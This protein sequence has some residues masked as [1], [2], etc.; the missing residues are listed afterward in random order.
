MAKS[1]KAKRQRRT[2]AQ[3]PQRPRQKVK[4]TTRDGGLPAPEAALLE[5]LPAAIAVFDADRR[6]AVF[7]TAFAELG[8]FPK[9][10][11]K[12]GRA[13]SEFQRRDASLR[14]RGP[15]PH[16]V[17]LPGGQV[18]Q[19]SKRSL[20]G[21][22]ILLC[23]ENVTAERLAAE[24]LDLVTRAS[25]E[26]TYDWD[27][28]NDTIYY[29][30]QVFEAIGLRRKDVPDA[31]AWYERIHPDDQPR[32]SERLR[33]HFRGET[34]RF[35]VEIRFRGP[36]GDW[37]WARQHGIGI[38]DARGKVVRMVGSTGDIDRLKRLEQ[39]LAESEARY[40]LATRAATEGIYDWNVGT[41]EL[42]LSDRAKTFFAIKGRKLTPAVWSSRIHAEDLPAY[43][44]V[45]ARY[46]KGEIQQFEHEYRIQ[47]ASGSYNWIQD[48][49]VAERGESGRVQ[50]LVG[51]ITDI[52]ARKQAEIE[53]LQAHDETAAALERQTATAEI[54]R[55]ISDS[56]TDVAP[57]LKAV[58][59]RAARICDAHT[60]D[61][62]LAE[63]QSMRMSAS[64]GNIGRPGAAESIPL[65]RE[66]VMGRAIVDRAVVQ[67]VDLQNPPEGEYALGRELARKYGHRTILAVPLLREGRALGAILVRRI[68]VR[69]FEDKHISLL[70]TFAD[71]AAIAIENVRLFNET[72]E[73][74]ERQTATA[75]VLKVISSS[76][77][78]TKPVFE[79][80]IDSCQGLIPTTDIVG[81]TFD[82]R[83]FVHVVATRGPMADAFANH[84]ARP[85]EET[86][87]TQALHERRVR[88]YP[89]PINGDDVPER[90]R[91]LSEQIGNFSWAV[92]PIL[93]ETRCVG[94]F[95]MTRKQGEVFADKEIDL[96]K[97]FADQ[98]AIAIQNSRLFNETEEAL[99]RQTATAE[100]LRVISSTPTDTQPVFD[101]IAASARR[102]CDA[103]A[104]VVLGYDGRVID[105]AALDSVNVEG[106]QQLRS[107]FPMPATGGSVS[108]RAILN[109]E[110]T[111]VPDVLEI[112]NYVLGTA[113][114]A[115]GYRS[116]LAVPMLREGQ[117]IGAITVTRAIPGLFPDRQ[118]EL[119][120]AFADQAVIAIENVRLFNETKEALE[121]QTATA[122]ILAAMSD[123]MTDA[124]PVFDAIV[125][126]LRRLFDTRF[127]VVQLLNGETIEM[128]AADGEPGFERLRDHYPRPLDQ[129]TIGAQTMLARRVIQCSPVIGNPE[130]AIGTQAFA[131]EFG[132]NA[133]LFAPMIRG[134]A[135]IGVIGI[136]HREPRVFDDDEV[137]LIKAFA[138]QAVIAIE[139]VRLFN[140]LK[141]RTEALTRSVGQLT[142]LGEVGQAISATLDVETVLKTIVS[143]AMRLTGLDAGVIYEYDIASE[144]F[145]LRASENFDDETVGTLRGAEL[146]VGEGAVGTS[147]SARKPTQVPDTHAPGYPARLR[148]ML[149]GPGFRAVLAVPLLREEQIIGALMMLRRAPGLFPT[150]VVELLSTF[151]SQSA[152]AMQ[153]ARLFREIGDKG[154]QLQVANQHKSEFLANMSH[155]LRTPLNAII[156]FS[157]ALDERYFGEL[158]D[159]QAE[160][161][162]DI[163]GSGK[164]L[165]SLINDILDLSKIEAG[166]MD[167]DLA[168]F[169]LPGA[170]DNALTL[171]RERAQ[172]HGVRLEHELD[173]AL[174][175]V[176]ADER[177]VKQIL[178]NLLS[179]AVKFTPEGGR[180]TVRGRPNGNMIEVAVVDTGVGIAP[181]DQA[182]VFEEFKQVGND[183]AAKAQGTGLGLALTKRF[184]ELHGGTIG[185]ES[186]P[187]KG[188][189]FIFTL[190][191]R[192]GE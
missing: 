7:N 124:Q 77:S 172:R 16:E 44:A 158:T 6:L 36:R 73:A 130:A 100:I 14:R 61:I 190:P 22:Q 12:P 188:S 84:A 28:V 42:Y 20:P 56:P 125:R 173:P 3:A 116:V 35:E 81:F 13:F 148:E 164:H 58:A 143:H 37:R 52:S 67:V 82:D 8:L 112:E 24:R 134:E 48:R 78:D 140:E 129:T 177:K 169:D 23:Y 156:G 86:F 91:K 146:R 101:A 171:V 1:S 69:P 34:D 68:E 99:E 165:L 154:Q 179:N 54:L 2:K 75:D 175:T 186:A 18:L 121:R 136:A 50:R 110:V 103:G 87:L 83:S 162:K 160:Y 138:D 63:G 47:S 145:Q 144:G 122:E 46:F 51:A 15:G 107:A 80:I 94:F 96:L 157:E 115:I 49:A 151:A 153:N 111:Q 43:R 41:G 64:V 187:G 59:E 183:V 102:L 167:L 192:G 161:V 133:A 159:K 149:D 55:V 135:V 90:L 119:L 142:A 4:P 104:V 26:G 108:T 141:S 19:A 66:T 5:A 32:Y 45:M 25:S 76:V 184:V 88:V 11:L 92:A 29:S 31:T 30:D 139:N 127:A 185:L 189:T 70:R 27:I 74:L 113:A 33:A 132:F 182:A 178:L 65:S 126:N 174:G 95:T 98:A 118:V 137:A 166:R 40:A 117:P 72:K 180:I 176:T 170:I 147:V 9:S 97:A 60:V 163:H 191:L 79:K 17:S 120:R 131:R 109:R 89:D 71:Q 155:E 105:V 181:E 168:E 152:L 21:R 38:R 106:A 10:L 93:T 53:L 39:A 150:E 128:P 57:V 123:S 114:N 85:V 62:V